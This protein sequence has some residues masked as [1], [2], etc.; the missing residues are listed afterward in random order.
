MPADLL[1]KKALSVARTLSDVGWPGVIAGKVPTGLPESVARLGQAQRPPAGR[2]PKTLGRSAQLTTISGV[3]EFRDSSREPT[4]V[5]V[6][7]GAHVRK[8]DHRAHLRRFNCAGVRA[9]VLERP[10]RSRPV[11]VGDVALQNAAKMLCIQ[12]D[13]VIQTLLT[14]GPDQS[15]AKAFCQGDLG[16]VVISSIANESTQRLNSAP[17][18]GSLSRSK[19]RGA[20]S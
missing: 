19:N 18:F 12:D 17:N 8:L 1:P 20:V 15:F 9:V 2:L 6:M 14:D 7:Q 11:V 13:E 10:V 5:P 4:S 3:T 16:A